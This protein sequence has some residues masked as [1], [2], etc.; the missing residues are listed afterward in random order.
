VT[1]IWQRQEIDSSFNLRNGCEIAG[2]KALT[3]VL[4][5]PGN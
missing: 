5:A 4:P 1:E 2:W 3:G